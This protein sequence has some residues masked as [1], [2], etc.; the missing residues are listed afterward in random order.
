KSTG[1]K[2]DST[3]IRLLN[4]MSTNL[5]ERYLVAK[6][7]ASAFYDANQPLLARDLTCC[8][9]GEMQGEEKEI[10]Y[11]ICIVVIDFAGLTTNCKDL[12]V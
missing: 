1:E 9:D 6:V 2:D 12:K 7:F 5:R 3:R 10:F 11:K 8:A 4:Q